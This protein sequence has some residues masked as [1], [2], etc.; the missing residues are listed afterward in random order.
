[1]CYAASEGF[2]FFLIILGGSI[3]EVLWVIFYKK[4]FQSLA[5]LPTE[6]ITYIKSIFIRLLLKSLG[7]IFKNKKKEINT[8][9]KQG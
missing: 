5:I 6:T 8:F 3:T 9:N 2:F 1:M 7:S 4:R